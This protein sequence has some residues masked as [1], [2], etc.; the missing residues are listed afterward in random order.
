ME[1]ESQKGLGGIQAN[2]SPPWRKPPPLQ[3]GRE[4]EIGERSPRVFFSPN[5]PRK[6]RTGGLEVATKKPRFVEQGKKRL[7]DML[8]KKKLQG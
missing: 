1:I 5:R 3:K 8:Q 6:G 4:D 7:S 2:L